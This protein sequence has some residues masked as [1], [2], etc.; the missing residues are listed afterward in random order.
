VRDHRNR[1][2]GAK[3]YAAMMGVDSQRLGRPAPERGPAPP[4]LTDLIYYAYQKGFWQSLRGH[5]FRL[6]LRRCGGR[7]FLGRHTK[8]LFPSHLSA[9]HNVA[10]GDYVYMNCLGRRGV[11]L[12]SNVRIRE[13]G[14]V[15]VTSQL[16]NP[17]EGIDIGNDTYIGP[18]C[19]LGAG[20]GISIGKSVMLGAYIQLLAE[21]HAFA[22]SHL[23]VSVQGVTRRGIAVEDNCWLGNGVIVLD[24]VRIGE[25]SVIGA[26]SVVTHDV[27]SRSVAVGNP[28][29]VIKTRSL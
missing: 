27:P 24:D 23:P 15:Q 19:V 29:R 7:F 11:T 6:R 5:V 17:G 9:G 28:A 18:H 26:G 8:I 1:I 22:D 25:H 20:G 13:F 2:A 10:I 14:S 3:L 16:T 21:N 12:G 4:R